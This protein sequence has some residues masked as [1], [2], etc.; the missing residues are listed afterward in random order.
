[1]D[2]YSKN[3]ACDEDD[4]VCVVT[5]DGLL[6]S[7]WSR[8]KRNSLL[9]SHAKVGPQIYDITENPYSITYQY[10]N[11]LN[12]PNNHPTLTKAQLGE[13]ARS[14]VNYMHHVLGIAHSDLSPDNVG[15]IGDKLYFIDHDELFNID[16]GITPWTQHL[17]DV[18]ECT[19]QQLVDSDDKKFSKW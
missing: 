18:N 13:Q 6:Y 16:E 8:I 3:V 19:F 9:L 14:M 17:M 5:Y 15:Y 7:E 10:V 11:P 2:S 4:T 1:M 12:T